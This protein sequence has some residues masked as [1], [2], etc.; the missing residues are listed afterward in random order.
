MVLACCS[1]SLSA[2]VL[3]Q[4][5][6]HGGP[7]L[8]AGFVVPMAHGDACDQPI[9]AGHLGAVEL[10]VLQVNVVHDFRNR[11]EGAVVEA[12]ARHKDL[13][14]AEVAVVRELSFKHVEAELLSLRLV[15]LGR[16]EL[17]AGVGVDKPANQPGARDAV[18]VN[19][20]SSH[21][22][23]TLKVFK[24]AVA[25]LRPLACG[26]RAKPHLKA[27]HAPLRCFAAWSSKEVDTTDLCEATPKPSNFGFDLRPT[28]FGECSPGK[29]GFKLPGRFGDLSVVGISR[30]V[31]GSLDFLVAQAFDEPRLAERRFASLLDNLPKH[32]LEVL[33]GVL[34][35]WKGV[36][37]VL[38]CD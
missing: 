30:G 14:S 8:E 34:G 20:L 19:A 31:E 24:P 15:A 13:K 26:R 1:P 7:T 6:K 16:H 36:D 9:D 33:S 22:D 27:A 23:T 5:V 35:V 29:L 32:P 4:V 10:R 17:D 2:E 37:G 18:D 28:V 38:D 21:P 3:V 25:G 11:H 12:E